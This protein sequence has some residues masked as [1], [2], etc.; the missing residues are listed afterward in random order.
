MKVDSR[1]LH[2]ES[3]CKAVF[4]VKH[5]AFQAQLQY[6][7]RFVGL[8]ASANVHIVGAGG[9]HPDLV[10]QGLQ[11]NEVM[12]DVS[13]RDASLDRYMDVQGE[14]FDVTKHLKE[15]EKKKNDTY[16][17]LCEDAG[18][19]FYPIIMGTRGAFSDSCGVFF[20]Q[21]VEELCKVELIEQAEAYRRIRQGLQVRVMKVIARNGL[22]GWRRLIAARGL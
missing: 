14:S 2:F 6:C 19:T 13:S 18:I 22:D 12:L 15:G 16:R 5:T 20:A 10:V 8:S 3:R 21:L 7:C 17:T 1:L 9:K 4:G 11:V